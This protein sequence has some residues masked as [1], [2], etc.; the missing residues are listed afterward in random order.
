MPIIH[1]NGRGYIVQRPKGKQSQF[2]WTYLWMLFN[3][4][5][6]EDGRFPYIKID[7]CMTPKCALF[8]EIILD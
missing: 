1:Q 6:K 5:V 2:T 7:I 8:K 4:S 3:W